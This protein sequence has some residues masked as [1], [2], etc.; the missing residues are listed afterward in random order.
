MGLINKCKPNTRVRR[1]EGGHFAIYG[2]PYRL[3]GSVVSGK[4]SKSVMQ[5]KITH[6]L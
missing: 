1:F 5:S 2:V 4:T 3:A 6:K